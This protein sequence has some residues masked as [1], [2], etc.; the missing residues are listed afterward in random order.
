MCLV[1]ALTLVL[2][3]CTKDDAPKVKTPFDNANIAKIADIEKKLGDNVITIHPEISINDRSVPEGE[4][5]YWVPMTDE[6]A[7]TCTFE[8]YRYN[9]RIDGQL[10]DQYKI[11]D[12]R[13]LDDFYLGGLNVGNYDF[14]FRVTDMDGITYTSNVFKVK[15]SGKY[16]PGFIVLSDVE[17]KTRVDFVNNLD[18]TMGPVMD[19]LS[20]TAAPA[21]GAPVGVSCT[22]DF[23]GAPGNL[24]EGQVNA[25]NG[26][27]IN[28][29]S[30]TN[31]VRLYWEDM[32]YADKYQLY[33]Q[34]KFMA[35]MGMGE[36]PNANFCPTV[37][38]S[39]AVN[40]S[41]KG[42]CIVYD[43]GNKEIRYYDAVNMVLW[44]ANATM[45]MNKIDGAKFTPS[46][47]LTGNSNSD[48]IAAILFNE[49][50]K[51]FVKLH[52][53]SFVTGGTASYY[54]E[55][56]LNNTG[57]ELVFSNWKFQAGND[58]EVV[59]IQKDAAGNLYYVSF[60]SNTGGNFRSN[61]ITAPKSSE[62][63]DF[64]TGQ[65]LNS[66]N[67]I[68][69]RTDTEIYAINQAN[70]TVTKVL[71]APEGMKF[72]KIKIE[73]NAID[74]DNAGWMNRLMVFS[75]DPEA[76]EH[77]CGTM[78]VYKVNEG[79]GALTLDVFNEKEMKWS[80]FGKVVDAAFKQK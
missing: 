46:P 1:A 66:P 56:G 16:T 78:E 3:G 65:S 11:A 74:S 7:E 42:E 34:F 20:G 40:E 60:K 37:I 64:T 39:A 5:G 61:Q 21:L 29:M 30:E 41:G 80:G 23:Y 48:G 35:G 25:A 47:V 10:Y 68:Y 38:Y 13:N 45:M 19:I 77:S 51:S 15:I 12:T 58:Q 62:A 54:T 26:Y 67:F 52:S 22:Y 76:S 32:S 31:M 59:A 6:I 17:G 14:F 53:V 24:F 28:I 2:S 72:S 69:Y 9:A 8:W 55:P 27:T 18:G 57:K 44:N 73:K 36:Y 70:L 33:N 71:D 4:E 49:D 43:K 50:N 75:Y 79:T 63:T